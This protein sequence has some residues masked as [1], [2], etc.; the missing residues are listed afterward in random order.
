MNILKINEILRNPIDE[1]TASWNRATVSVG[2]TFRLQ[3]L[4]SSEVS[5]RGNRL[6]L[7]PAQ[8]QLEMHENQ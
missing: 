6:D 5:L 8:R 1:I 2:A 3:R 7:S 4:E